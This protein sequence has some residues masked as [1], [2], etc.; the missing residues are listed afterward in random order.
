MC[1]FLLLL[2]VVCLFSCKY[3]CSKEATQCI[4]ARLSY[5]YAQRSFFLVLLLFSFFYISLNLTHF[6]SSLFF[7]SLRYALFFF[8]CCYYSHTHLTGIVRLCSSTSTSSVSRCVTS[9][10]TYIHIQTKQTH[11]QKKKDQRGLTH[12]E[13]KHF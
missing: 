5:I 6:L 8:F 4:C 7:S 1:V 11:K 10:F 13:N 9:S 2:L 3:R 12:H